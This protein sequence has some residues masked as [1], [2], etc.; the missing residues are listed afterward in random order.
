MGLLSCDPGWRG[1]AFT[2]YIPSLNY[3]STRLFQLN[4]GAS[5]GYKM[6]FNTIPLLVEAIR[7]DYLNSE[8]RLLLVDKIIIESQYKTNMQVLSYLIV[9]VLQT[10][11]PWTKV[12]KISALK[13]KRM[14]NIPLGNSH[15]ENKQRMLEYVKA[16]KNELIGGET[17]TNHD[18][19]DSIILLNTYLKEKKRRLV[20]GLEEL[21]M[22]RPL[23][24]VVCPH[25]GSKG[26]VYR[27]KKEGPTF[28][29]LFM[30]C[31]EKKQGG[32]CTSKDSFKWIKDYTPV[33]DEDGISRIAG[34]EEWVEPASQT[35]KRPA[36]VSASSHKKA[37]PAK[38]AAPST[39]DKGVHLADETMARFLELFANL[40]N[41]LEAHIDE[42][43]RELANEKETND[44]E[45]EVS[46][47]AME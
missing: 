6:P 2:L 47:E 4:I 12:E 38:K 43:F 37:P 25:C 14:F 10:L 30:S 8:H 34:W 19:A 46:Q 3:V 39:A 42:R 13:C 24:E 33:I 5:K 41:S 28:G 45:A 17:V 20:T 29:K 1:L 36:T 7:N 23:A 32:S 26:G 31:S 27:V 18:T 11:L 21:T 40:K 22:S 9:A 35:H 16:H 44:S 15:Y